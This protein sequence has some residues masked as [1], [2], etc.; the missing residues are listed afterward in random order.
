MNLLELALAPAALSPGRIALGLALS[1]AIG[2]LG[3]WRRS[4][5]AS[6]WLGAVLVGTATF[7][8]G[9][10]AWGLV[11]I[12]FFAASS[13]LSKLGKRLKLALAADKFSKSDQRDLW[14]AL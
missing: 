9:G 1:A 14:Q 5:T 2:G 4:L 3:F 10:W 8:F 12:V 6:G 7:G 11:V 13:A